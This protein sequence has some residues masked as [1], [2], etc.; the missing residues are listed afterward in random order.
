MIKKHDFIELTYTGI[1]QDTQ[2]VFDTTDEKEAKKAHIYNKNMD[3]S[4]LIVCVGENQLLPGLDKELIGK[5]LK[6]YTLTLTPENAFG[7]KNPKLLHLL[8]QTAFKKQNITPYPGLQVNIDGMIGIVRTV[9]PGRVIV[10]FNHPLAGKTLLY[11]IKLLKKITQPPQQLNSLIKFYT[12][13]FKS[14]IKNST[15]ILTSKSLPPQ[16]HKDLEKKITTLI[17]T[18]KKLTIKKE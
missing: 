2:Q 1:I 7:K 6:S 17:P 3:Y 16:V 18:I 9:T 4:P 5:D 11:K 14:E 12:K 10:D 15:A 13:D 8:S